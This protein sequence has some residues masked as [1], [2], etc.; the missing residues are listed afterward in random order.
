[1][2]DEPGKTLELVVFALKEGTSREQFLNSDAAATSWMRQQPGF[3]SHELSEA[4]D[5]GRWIEVA[6]WE[7]RE[8]AEAAAQAAMTSESCAPMFSLIEME[9]SLMF[10]GELVTAAY[11]H[12]DSTAA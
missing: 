12:S 2:F 6:W 1:V 11:A 8:A 10:H 7:S 3:I 4:A 9:S 5:G